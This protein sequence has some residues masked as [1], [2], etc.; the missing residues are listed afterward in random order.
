MITQR[1]LGIIP[2]IMYNTDTN[3]ADNDINKSQLSNI[4][5][6][7]NILSIQNPETSILYSILNSNCAS[8]PS[9]LKNKLNNHITTKYKSNNNLNMANIP[10]SRN[11]T[12]QELQEHSTIQNNT[13]LSLHSSYL[14]PKIKIKL[15]TQ[16]LIKS[17]AI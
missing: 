1:K 2:P 15:L 17:L 4:Y 9:H 16:K 12:Q 13:K 11:I 7:Q 14:Y 5:N 6:H 10:S 3:H 8:S